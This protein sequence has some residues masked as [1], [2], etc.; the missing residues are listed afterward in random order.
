M[1][2]MTIHLMGHNAKTTVHNAPEFSF[3]NYLRTQGWKIVDNYENA[4]VVLSIDSEGTLFCKPK[5]PRFGVNQS[6]ILLIQEPGVVWPNN[7]L[8][9]YISA[10]N[11][12]IYLGRANMGKEI[13]CWP[14]IWPSDIGTNFRMQKINRAV[15]IASN[16]LSFLEGELYS[17]RR[18]AVRKIEVL[19]TYGRDWDIGISKRTARLAIEMF[20]ALVR[21]SSMSFNSAR[22]Y[23]ISPPSTKGAIL[24]KQSV[25]ARYKVS[26]VI[27][28]SIDY[29]SEKLLEALLAGS[30]PVYVG[31]DPSA[32]GIPEELV[33]HVEP[34]L[35]AIERAIRNALE[36]NYDSWSE[37]AQNW[38]LKPKT[39]T[40]WS[41]TEFWRKLHLRLLGETQTK[42]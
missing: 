41:V 29:M 20:S 27:E 13:M 23:L 33:L 7:S 3:T 26:L 38:L 21:G 35:Q 6:S 11:D 37:S 32:F 31:P 39:A 36:L 2:K 17:L 14:I 5:V 9:N 24:D 8:Q 25:N 10:F 16:R 4:A 18:M 22:D 15:F 1:E 19:D 42:V 28:N 30:I 34:N 12:V 40:N